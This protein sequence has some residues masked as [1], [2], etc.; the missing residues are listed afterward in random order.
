MENLAGDRPFSAGCSLGI[1]AARTALCAGGGRRPHSRGASLITKAGSFDGLLARGANLFERWHEH[2]DAEIY[3]DLPSNDARP[4]TAFLRDNGCRLAAVF[5]EDRTA[6]ES[7]YN[8]YYAFEHPHDRRYLLVRAPVPADHPAFPS[9]AVEIPAVNWQER[10]I[11]DWFGLVAGKPPHPRPAALLGV[12]RRSV[13]GHPVGADLEFLIADHVEQREA[14]DHRAEQLGALGESR[15]HQQA[16]VRCALNGDPFGF[17]VVVGDE[18]TGGADEIVEDVLLLLEHPPVV[19]LL[20]ELRAPAQVGHREDA[21]HLRPD[22]RSLS[23][24]RCLAH[25]EAA[26]TREKHRPIA[27]EGEPLLVHHEHRDAGLVARLVPNLLHFEVHWIERDVGPEP[28]LLASGRDL[29]AIARLRL[30]ER[31]IAEEG[32][33]VL[34]S[35]RESEDAADA[36][37]FDVAQILARG[38][39]LLDAWLDVF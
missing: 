9:L 39:V 35:A 18:P 11:Q 20:A 17:G 38:A 8:L 36:G 34:P 2:G 21:T 12:A 3:A 5:A 1:L 33:V 10:E 6:A 24:C 29:V 37:K 4:V 16:A 28:D 14:A 26:V 22:H 19:P 7:R 31:R 25:V 15:A 23:E 30:H 32:F 13:F 27:V